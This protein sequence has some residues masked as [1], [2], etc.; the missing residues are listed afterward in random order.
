MKDPAAVRLGRKGGTNSRAN[1]SE[2]QAS[3]LGRSAV[4]ERW[5]RYYEENPDKWAE[6][7]A[8]ET[9]KG[10]VPRGRPPKKKA[11]AGK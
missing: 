5:R 1:M 9:R 6:R 11:K 10:T 3:D 8:R 2:A 4:S 7:Q